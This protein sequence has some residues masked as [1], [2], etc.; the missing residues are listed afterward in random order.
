MKLSIITINYN[1]AQGLEKTIRSIVEQT[2]TDFEYIVIDGGS[3]DGSTDVINKYED[4]IDYWVSEPDKGIYNAMNKGIRQAKGEYIL[5]VNSGDTLYDDNAIE[6]IFSY[7]LISDLVY[8]DLHRILADGDTDIVRMPDKIDV[9]YLLYST[10]THPTTLIRRN[11][12]EKY[13]LYR[14]DLKIVSDWAFFLKLIAFTNITRQHIPVI[15]ATFSMDGISS[16]EDDLMMQERLKVIKESFSFEL[17]EMYELYDKY[18]KFYSK[19]Y[20][21]IGRRITSVMKSIFSLRYWNQLIHRRRMN[22]LIYI[23]NKTVRKQKKES[24]SIPVI[25][26]NYNRLADLKKIV[27]FLLDRKHKNIV[28][29]D[30]KSSYPPLLAYYKEIEDR[31]TIEMM[32]KNYGHLVFWKNE[33]LQELYGKGYY[34]VTDSDILPNDKMPSDY[35]CQMMHLLDHYK[36]RTKVGWALRL[37]D[38]PD[39]FKLKQKVIDWETRFW[40]DKVASDLYV[41]QVD[42]TFALYPPR[43]KYDNG[44]F[45]NGLR[46]AGDF[47]AKHGG[48]YIDPDNM[49]EEE[50]FY[51]QTSNASNSW[52]MNKKG[53]NI[54]D[55]EY[56]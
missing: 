19:S 4:R 35:L 39:Y 7:P 32:D 38:I 5:F 20:F 30:N 21:K 18:R 44:N 33:R 13:G 22:L 42:T 16:R 45:L 29:V 52:K 46:I 8:G 47:T 37:D 56:R 14:E 28:I 6:N 43:Y 53:E 50:E 23:F 25:I 2:I 40:E 1:N 41:A 11:L 15:V 34:V 54:G 10:L 3:E 36:D 12:F 17:L 27:D 51:F 48:W 55:N 24:L 49:T 26:I 9:K 31:V